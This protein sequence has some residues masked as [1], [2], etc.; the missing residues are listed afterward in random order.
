MEEGLYRCVYIC[1]HFWIFVSAFYLDYFGG[2]YIG[3]FVCSIW[4]GFSFALDSFTCVY[5]I[6]K[7][8]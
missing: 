6:K 3:A 1:E 8:K 5:S 2:F 7:Y 4:T